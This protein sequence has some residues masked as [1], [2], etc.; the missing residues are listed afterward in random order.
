[1]TE[2]E[3]RIEDAWEVVSLLCGVFL[4]G[5]SLYAPVWILLALGVLKP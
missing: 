2:H 5:M 1:M 4:T 3:K